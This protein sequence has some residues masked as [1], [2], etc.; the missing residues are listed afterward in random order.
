MQ[1]L[2]YCRQFVK[3]G[4]DGRVVFLT[5]QRLLKSNK[6]NNETDA[7]AGLIKISQ[8]FV[9]PEDAIFSTDNELRAIV[10]NNNIRQPFPIIALEYATP[11]CKDLAGSF[12][13]TKKIVLSLERQMD[14]A[15]LY[16]PTLI[17]IL[18]LDNEDKWIVLPLVFGSHIV[19]K[20]EQ[21]GLLQSLGVDIDEE[22][23][24]D[25]LKL[26]LLDWT[27][28]AIQIFLADYYR[29]MNMC[30]CSNVEFAPAAGCD[31][32]SMKKR[33]S[34]GFDEYKVLMVSSHVRAKGESRGGSH[35]SP[36]EHLRRG[37]IRRI[38]DERRVWVNAT[39][40]CAGSAGRITKDY[41][42]KGAT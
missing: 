32:A 5:K 21:T 3:A 10:G 20:N 18:Y 1:P 37:H 42:I 17:P 11:T 27:R 38:D 40:V 24:A 39:V 26:G 33:R 25:L 19:E 34:L 13:S 2:N 23:K 9:L 36:R 29:F 8:K 6:F 28:G 16:Y 41:A 35:A 30:Q 31:R 7:Y 4:I 12:V 14:D 22:S 15:D